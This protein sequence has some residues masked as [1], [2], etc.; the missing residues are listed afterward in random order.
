MGGLMKGIAFLLLFV[1]TIALADGA[2]LFKQNC[3][4]CHAMDGSANTPAGKS[5]K[6]KD[7]RSPAV[8]KKTDEE[9]ANQIRNG[10]GPMPSFKAR[11]KENDIA[12]L[13]AFIRALAKK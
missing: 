12:E 5:L 3:A 1:P 10:K 8:Q 2:P 9:L 6:A 4:P 13:V 7:L 11:F